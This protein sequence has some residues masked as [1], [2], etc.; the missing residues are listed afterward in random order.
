MEMEM[1]LE[2]MHHELL[3]CSKEQGATQFLIDAWENAWYTA[4][5]FPGEPLPCP[6]CFLDGRVER[7]VPLPSVSDRGA[8]RCEA[9]KTKFEFAGG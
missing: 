9:C 3:S 5:K 8:A 2:G 7:L 6:Q 4:Q 1:A